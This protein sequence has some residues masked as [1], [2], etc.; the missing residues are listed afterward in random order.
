MTWWYLKRRSSGMSMLET[1]I[2]LGLLVSAFAVFFRLYHVALGYAAAG[3]RRMQA[4][5]VAQRQLVKLRGWALEANGT[6][7]N[8]DD[9]SAYTDT[10]FNDE[11]HPAYKVRIQSAFVTSVSPNSSLLAGPLGFDKKSLESSTRKVQITVSWDSESLLVASLI[12]S[13]PRQLR[14]I[15]PVEISGW[16]GGSVARDQS[17]PLTVKVYDSNDVQIPDVMAR[18]YVKP[19]NGV[20]KVD[21]PLEGDSATFINVSEKMDG[22]PQHTGGQCRVRARVVYRGREVWGESDIMDLAP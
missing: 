5:S 1:I 10:S 9:W 13:P 16:S 18:W 19:I 4:A 21:S 12:A 8:F 14:R 20:G 3:E 15:N 2:A 7:T 22:T 6:G 11:E 17:I